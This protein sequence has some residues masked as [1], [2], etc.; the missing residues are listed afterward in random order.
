MDS[1]S[2]TIQYSPEDLHESYK[3][4][5]RHYYPIRSRLLLI[6]GAV[7]LVLS[8][9]LLLISSGDPDDMGL[10]RYLGWVFFIYAIVVVGIYLWRM[11]TLGRRMFKKMPDF[12]SPYSFQFSQ[13]GIVTKGASIASDAEWSYYLDAIITPDLILLMP[14]KLRFIMFPRRYFTDDQFGQLTQWAEAVR[15]RRSGA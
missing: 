1:I 5:F 11:H 13:R 12:Q 2:L 15:T 7:T 4:Y 3:L 8:I 6:L 9:L 14:N 10:Y